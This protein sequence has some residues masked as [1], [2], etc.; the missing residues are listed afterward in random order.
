MGAVGAIGNKVSTLANA[1][2]V[3]LP[4]MPQ[5]LTDAGE[6][7]GKTQDKLQDFIASVTPL[8]KP[9]LTTP[10]GAAASITGNA[11]GGGIGVGQTGAIEGVLDRLP[12]IASK[13]VSFALPTF[14]HMGTNIP[15][16]TALGTSQG[17]ADIALKQP[18]FAEHQD[19]QAPAAAPDAQTHADPL[20]AMSADPLMAMSGEA[21]PEPDMSALSSVVKHFESNGGDYNAQN[22]TSSASGAYGF[23]DSTWKQYANAAGVDTTQY[24]TAKS[25]P[26]EVQDAVFSTAVRQNGLKDWTCPGCDTNLSKYLASNPGI[27]LPQG[28]IT[29]EQVKSDPLLAMSADTPNAPAAGTAVGPTFDQQGNTGTTVASAAI[30]LLLMLGAAA[31]A[32]PLYGLG[33]E[34]GGAE[35]EHMRFKDTAAAQQAQDHQDEVIARGDA[36]GQFTPPNEQTVTPANAYARGQ[37]VP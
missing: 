27:A 11:V 3:P 24:P 16:S 20:Q 13:V 31:G 28:A 8:A 7:F 21:A 14:G 1:A 17:A 5:V 37:L 4:S 26:P 12:T 35:R 32:H 30:D 33:A 25:A 23:I 15:I 34:V 18:Q 36:P 29:P 22:P 2:G 6:H 19:N 10:E 9:D